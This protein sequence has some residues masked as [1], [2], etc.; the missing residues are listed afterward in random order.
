MNTVYMI[1]MQNGYG[2]NAIH[3]IWTT[4]DGASEEIIRL[5]RSQ[6]RYDNNYYIQP[7]ELN[8][9]LLGLINNNL[10]LNRYHD[11]VQE[12]KKLTEQ[13]KTVAENLKSLMPEQPTECVFGYGACCYPIDDC[14]NCP[15]HSWS[16]FTPPLTT[17]EFK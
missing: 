9:D 1:V 11:E 2:N 3:S 13:L 4:I 15:M 17:C 10:I 12:N 8:G 7:K 5:V 16:D 14:G 6:E